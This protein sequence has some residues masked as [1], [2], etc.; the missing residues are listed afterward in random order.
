MN[1]NRVA[2]T[3]INLLRTLCRPSTLASGCLSVAVAATVFVTTSTEVSAHYLPTRH[4][5]L[6]FDEATQAFLDDRISNGHPAGTPILQN[7]DEVA[8]VIKIVPRDGEGTGAGGHVDFYI[9]DGTQVIDA[10]YIVPGGDLSDGIIEFDK[11]PIKSPSLIT[12]DE[13]AGGNANAAVGSLIPLRTAPGGPHGPNI[14][15]NTNEIVDAGGVHRG[16]IAGVYGD[17]G[18]FWATDPDTAYGSWQ[19]YTE[20][21]L[22]F[23]G[24]TAGEC[25]LTGAGLPEVVITGRTIKGSG[26]EETVPCNKWDVDQMMGWGVANTSCNVAPCVGS[27]LVDNNGRGNS[28]WGFASGVAGPQSGYAWEFDWDVFNSTVGTQ[29]QKLEASMD[30]SQIGPW[31]RIRYPGSR[32]SNDTPGDTNTALI[33]V[34]EDASGL[35]TIVSP[36]FPLPQT[37]SQTD[38]SSPK[39]IRW[40]VGQLNLEIPDYVWVKIR[41]NDAAAMVPAGTCPVINA[42]TF[43]GDAGGPDGGKDHLWRYYDPSRAYLNLCAAIGKP[44]NTTAVGVGDTVVYNIKAYNAGALTL[45]GVVISDV[46]SADLIFVSSVPAQTSGPNPLVYDLGIIQG[47]GAGNGVL[48]PGEGFEATLTVTAD[49]AALIDNTICISSNEAPDQCSRETITVG[50]IPILEQLKTASAETVA[51][52]GQL[53]YTITINNTGTGPTADAP[54]GINEFLPPG[55][56]YLSL[57]SASINGGNALLNTTVDNS[58]PTQPIFEINDTLIPGQSAV[59]TFRA[60][61]AGTVPALDEYCNRYSVYVKDAGRATVSGS[62]ACVSLS[63][64]RGNVSLDTTGDG[65]GDTDSANVLIQLYTDPNGDGNPSDGI[66]VSTAATDQNGDYE[67]FGV[68]P[69]NYVLVEID[70]AGQASLSDT[71]SLEND[72]VA[73]G[74]VASDNYIPVTMIIGEADIN[75][76]FVDVISGSITGI[77]WLDEDQDGV[78]DIEEGGFTNVTVELNDGVCTPGVNCP[79]TITDQF[80]NY[81]FEGLAPNSYSITVIATTLPAGVIN[82]AGQFGIPTRL[83]SLALGQQVSDE[84]FGYIANMDRGIIGD[85]VWSDVNANG[86]QDPGEAGIAGV[87]LTLTDAD[88]NQVGGTVTSNSNGDYLFTDVLF[89][90]D[91]IV[92][93]SATDTALL[94][95]GFLPELAG[96][97]GPTSG[98]QS[99][100]SLISNPVSL[101]ASLTTVTDIDFGFDN[102]LPLTLTIRDRIWYDSDADQIQDVGEPGIA[103]ISVDLLDLFGQVVAT[104][105]TDANGDF[106]FSGVPDRT[107]YRLR[108]SDRNNQLDA[109]QETTNTLG[110]ATIIGLLS[111]AVNGD[112]IVDTVGDDGT[113]TFGFNNPGLIAGVIYSDPNNSSSQD[114]NE[115]GL[116]GIVVT[117]EDGSGNVLATTTTL[118]DGS[119]QFDG[120]IP[121]A[122]V[123]KVAQPAPTVTSQTEDPDVGIPDNQTAITLSV[124][125]SSIGN[126]FGYVYDLGELHDVSGTVFLDTDKDGVEETGEPGIPSVTLDLIVPA[127]SVIDGLIDLNGD[128]V[129]SA[130]DDGTY[131]GFTV[132][133][134]RVDLDGSGSINAADDGELNGIAIVN[135]EFDIDGNG[136]LDMLDDAIL[137][138]A[139]IASTASDANGDYSFTGLPDGDYQVK[140][141]DSSGLLA[142]Y[143]ITSGLDTRNAIV[144]GADVFDVDFGYVKDQATAAITSGAWVDSD[145]DG[146]RDAGETPIAGVD[147]NLIN[148][149][150]DAIC[151]GAGAAD[152]T[153]VGTATTDAQGNVIFPNLAPGNYQLDLDETDPDLPANFVETIYTGVDPNTPIALSE[154]ETYDADF[155]YVSNPALAALSGVLWSDADTDGLKDIGEAP[156]AGITVTLTD[157]SGSIVATA[158]TGPDGRYEFT[159]LT[160]C[161]STID[162][163]GIFYDKTAVDATGLNGQEPTN[164]TDSNGDGLNDDHYQ[165]HLS[166]GEIVSDLNY[167]FAGPDDPG[168]TVAPC[169]PTVSDQVGSIEGVVYYEPTAANPNGS[170]GVDDTGIEQVSLSLVDASGNI[171]AT[172]F[173]GDGTQ[174]A[175][176]DGF[177]NSADIGYYSFTGIVPGI[178]YEIVVSDT[179]NA[180]IGLNPSGDPDELGLCVTC[181]RT[182]SAITVLANTVTTSNFGYIG[183]QKLGNIGNLIWLDVVNDGIFSP[184][185]GDIGLAGVTVQCW[186][187]TDNN[188]VFGNGIFGPNGIDNLI[189]TVTT[190]ANGEYYCAGLPTGIY[191]VRV[192]DTGG[193]L[194]GFSAATVLGGTGALT[195]AD[196]TNKVDVIADHAWLVKTGSDNLTADFAVSGSFELSGNVFIEDKDL[197]EP[198]DDGTSSADELDATPGDGDDV[199]AEGVTMLLLREQ[200]DGSFIQI[201]SVLTDVDGNYTFSSLPPGNYKV[202]VDPDGSPVDGFGQTADPDLTSAPP[203]GPGSVVE[204]SVCDSNTASLCDNTASIN[205]T[206][207]VAGVNFGYQDGFVTTPVT[208]D[209]FMARRVGGDIEFEWAASNEVGHVGYQI[210]ARTKNGWKL[211]N[212]QLIVSQGS[213]SAMSTVSYSYT[214]NGV[215]A[216]WFSLVD[217][218]V[219][220][221]LTPHGPFEINKRYGEDLERPEVF[222]WSVI[223]GQKS[224]SAETARSLESRLER[225]RVLDI[226]D[227]ESVQGDLNLEEKLEGEE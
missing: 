62:L 216:K 192:T 136:S 94:A 32:V 65:L 215:D 224:D 102:P 191:F 148:C 161:T 14:L 53:D 80:G 167:G 75:N 11:R 133:D 20:N 134:G 160:P 135:G 172:T 149:G 76:D 208:V 59:L 155:G 26:G 111:T 202:V 188:E 117:L 115:P 151:G 157:L 190:D 128:G 174:D 159:G 199:P 3:L 52:G 153:V 152:D 40:S 225:F 22:G 124:G 138:A 120:L 226:A 106:S 196:N 7:G 67:F 178:G 217:V 74:A 96:P 24:D 204:R 146:V 104:T 132:I 197:V 27:P 121:G 205:L 45:T 99:E 46:I 5:Y 218:S 8:F 116:T 66:L 221:V 83:V 114:S 57:L 143:D 38:S 95:D 213:A 61:F 84:D 214:A 12:G 219:A 100:G 90:N 13:G 89:G 203:A 183:E 33:D 141:T 34:S 187:D 49:K 112:G 211:L 193:V 21:V 182:D 63:V 85:R 47:V 10:A 54:L 186:V 201:S 227:D 220:E 87:E 105:V 97:G 37:V 36:A 98:P 163:Y 23:V 93:I 103:G 212:E 107:N 198:N 156:L 16:T 113:P 129:V 60:N 126:D 79:T 185:D 127:E 51:P 56:T 173:T 30:K 73:N 144:A 175:N 35:G 58:D 41:V 1:V 43:G 101:S 4:V 119:Y 166:A 18:I 206:A 50:S 154:G 200:P 118:A 78:N 150:L 177:I 70:P 210:F 68:I 82:T 28:P 142:G 77:V 86:I 169:D 162:C 39:T 184:D 71:Q 179:N 130:A 222:D 140:V 69:G 176:G 170:F 91:Y 64:I 194:N 147:I 48:Q 29:Q 125:S 92:S 181:D 158:V 131:L 207:N 123:V 122:Y 42:D 209:N 6:Y 145:G 168:C 108:V 81:Y 2:K 171:I 110:V 195:D 15:G 44:T 31:Q 88:G 139:V 189:R 109:L 180:L 164:T 19:R 9:P 72:V 55:F 17:T 165:V 25:G 223:A 137:P